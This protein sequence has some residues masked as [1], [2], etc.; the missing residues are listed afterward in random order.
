MHPP[1]TRAAAAFPAGG[2]DHHFPG[3][4]AR[5]GSNLIFRASV[6]TSVD[7]VQNTAQGP[8]DSGVVR[9]ELQAVFAAERRCGKSGQNEQDVSDLHGL[10]NTSAPEVSWIRLG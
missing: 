8:F 5:S 4:G 9:R 10:S 2:V 6:Q 7:S 3:C 1:V